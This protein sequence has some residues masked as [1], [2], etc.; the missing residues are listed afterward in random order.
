MMRYNPSTY[1][2]EVNPDGKY[3]Y[4]DI[5]VKSCP[6]HLL[7]DN[8]ACVRSCLPYKKEVNGECVPCDGPCPK[9]CKGVSNFVHAGNIDSFRGCTVI[10]GSLTIL[11]STFTGFQE[12]FPNNTLGPLY[13]EMHPK[14]LDIFNTLREVTEYISIQAKHP[15]FKNLAFL[16]HLEVIRGRMVTQ[17]V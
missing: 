7:R 14:Q 2:W 13:R 5:C 11:D 1:S 9:T 3:A 8:G 10:E 15:D 4:G 6:D 17:Y 16:R 12:I